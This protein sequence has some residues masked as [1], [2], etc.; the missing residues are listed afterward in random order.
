VPPSRSQL[1]IVRSVVE[2]RR[3]EDMSLI[4]VRIFFPNVEERVRTVPTARRAMAKLRYA[5]VELEL[6]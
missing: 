5:G 6:A 4:G 3:G 1:P 2:A